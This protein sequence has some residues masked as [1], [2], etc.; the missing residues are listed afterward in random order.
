MDADEQRRGREREKKKSSLFGEHKKTGFFLSWGT[1]EGKERKK[2]TMGKRW[3]NKRCRRRRYIC[4]QLGSLH[5]STFTLEQS[6]PRHH[7]FRTPTRVEKEGKSS[8]L[9]SL[10]LLYVTILHCIVWYEKIIKTCREFEVDSLRECFI[11]WIYKYRLRTVQHDDDDFLFR[12]TIIS[13]SHF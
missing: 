4:V 1:P 3:L 8:L 6:G 11:T 13:R 9:L 2:N 7:K 12:D 10:S 5:I